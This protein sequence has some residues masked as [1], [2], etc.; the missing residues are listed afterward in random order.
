MHRNATIFPN[1]DTFDP[2][3]WLDADTA[4]RL[5]R[6]LVAFSKGSRQCVGIQ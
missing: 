6:Y 3:R 5:E 1:P 2:E 4:K